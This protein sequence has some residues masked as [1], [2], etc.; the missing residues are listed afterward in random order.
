MA[1]SAIRFGPAAQQPQLDGN[2]NGVA[3]EL[4]DNLAANRYS[5]GT[6]ILL[7]GD[8]P[9]IGSISAPVS[10]LETSAT[11][12][13][14][15]VTSTSEIS[16]VSLV[17]SQADG[18]IQNLPMTLA[19]TSTYQASIS[20]SSPLVVV[21]AYAVDTDGDVSLPVSLEVINDMVFRN[22]FE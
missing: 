20:I 15:D 11:V 19:G 1:R 6:G 13:V 4:F 16:G 3:N 5:I 18:S 12:T 7:A 9:V 22:D 17:V 2:G 14:S 21:S 8:E 10:T